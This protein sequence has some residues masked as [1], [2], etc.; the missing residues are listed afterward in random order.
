MNTID[1]MLQG[2]WTPAKRDAV[3]EEVRKL[4]EAAREAVR[5]LN[6]A[7]GL[8]MVPYGKPARSFGEIADNLARFL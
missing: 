2:T 3:A 7:R 5:A 1:M 4:Q 8:T 6:C